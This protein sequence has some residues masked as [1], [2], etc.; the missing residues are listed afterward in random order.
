MKLFGLRSGTNE[1]DIFSSAIRDFLA[2]VLML[3]ARTDQT[4]QNKTQH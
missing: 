4:P 3:I 2:V 1:A